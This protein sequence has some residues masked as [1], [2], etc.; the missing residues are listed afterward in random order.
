MSGR[1]QARIDVARLEALL[2]RMAQQ[3][4]LVIGDVLLDAYLWGASER[5]SPEAPVPVVRVERESFALGGAGNV[6]R[7][8]VAL[9]AGCTL[10]GVVG[11]DGAGARVT[12]LAAAEGI[13]SGVVIDPERPTT[14]K[15]RVVARGQQMLRIDREIALPIAARVRSEI[16]SE[17]GR[18]SSKVD[19]AILADYGK[20]VLPRAFSRA[21]MGRFAKSDVPVAVDPK[22]ELAGYRGAA[23]VKPNRA[24]AARLIGARDPGTADCMHLIDRLRVRLPG[25]DLAITEGARGMTIA[26]AGD[27]PIHVP[28]AARDIFDVQGA[29]DTTMAAI[30]LARLAGGSLLESALI[31]NAAAGVVVGKIGTASAHRD[32]V[33]ER[34]AGIVDAFRENA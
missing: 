2:T 17:L 26:E 15:S 10:I 6:A 25:S 14:L 12:E 5:I 27:R 16:L 11:D 22:Q 34:L 1:R 20:G 18:A 23:L 29:G 30:W 13:E 7:N 4:V 32:E 31:A 8:V 9:G 21:L 19:G 3:H 28:T 24:E 33:G